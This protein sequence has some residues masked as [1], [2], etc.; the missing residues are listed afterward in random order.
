M[1]IPPTA[2]PIQGRSGPA[3]RYQQTSIAGESLRKELTGT[4]TVHT[5]ARLARA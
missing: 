1:V 2:T 5:C 3:I 4:G